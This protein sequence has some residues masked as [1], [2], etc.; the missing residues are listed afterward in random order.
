MWLTQAL[1]ARQ[2]AFQSQGTFSKEQ[3]EKFSCLIP[4]F[5]VKFHFNISENIQS[6]YYLLNDCGV[7]VFQIPVSA[8]EVD[9]GALAACLNGVPLHQRLDIPANH[10]H[11]STLVINTLYLYFFTI[12]FISS[13]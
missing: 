3:V 6:C 8:L 12:L 11:V 5:D 9:F 2:F 4:V 10:L 13:T 1:E 7:I